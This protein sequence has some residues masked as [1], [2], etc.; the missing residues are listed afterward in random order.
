MST[1]VT[2]AGKGDT[3]SWTE[4]DSNFTN[5]NNDKIQS[6]NA[7]TTGQILTKTAGGAQWA[8]PSGGGNNIIILSLANNMGIGST[9]TADLGGNPD[10]NSFNLRSSG[11]VSGVSVSSANFTLPAGTYM[12]RM[13][14]MI[15][16]N[17]NKDSIRLYNRSTSSGVV[18]WNFRT[19]TI[20]GTANCAFW[21]GP[22]F[23]FTIGSSNSFTFDPGSGGTS[24]NVYQDHSNNLFCFE[25]HK[26][27]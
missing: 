13:P 10:G 22:S 5:L 1:I 4:V 17:A 14:T 20:N 2:R 18:S 25:I 19:M 21:A 12:I 27:A 26:L 3:L 24:F 8:T 7:G 15:T 16:H 23:V 11:G 6:S 9:Q